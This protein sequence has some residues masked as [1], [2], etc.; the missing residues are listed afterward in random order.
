[1]KCP[2]FSLLCPQY[3]DRQEKRAVLETNIDDESHLDHATNM[4]EDTSNTFKGR[5][6]ASLDAFRLHQPSAHIVSSCSTSASASPSSVSGGSSFD[7]EFTN[8]PSASLSATKNRAPATGVPHGRRTSMLAHS[9]IQADE[10]QSDDE[11]H[12]DALMDSGR[13]ESPEKVQPPAH[14]RT[15]SSLLP[16]PAMLGTSKSTRRGLSPSPGSPK[17]SPGRIMQEMN[18][19]DKSFNPL[20]P[21]NSKPQ[22]GTVTQGIRL[23]TPPP[24]ASFT[25][26][27]FTS[28]PFGGSTARPTGLARSKTSPSMRRPRAS[29]PSASSGYSESR[30]PSRDRALTPEETQM[31]D[32]AVNQTA[33]DFQA[34]FDALGMSL[35]GDEDVLPSPISRGPVRRPVQR[36]GS[37]MVRTPSLSTRDSIQRLTGPLF[38]F[39]QPKSKQH[40][41]VAQQLEDEGNDNGVDEVLSEAALHRLNSSRPSMNV[42]SAF[43]STSKA[44]MAPVPSNFH[45]NPSSYPPQNS[46]AA[47]ANRFPESAAED[48]FGAAGSSP[49]SENDDIASVTQFEMEEDITGASMSEAESE[50]KK[51]KEAWFGFRERPAPNAGQQAVTGSASVSST[52]ASANNSGS[53]QNHGTTAVSRPGKRKMV[54]DE[55]FEPYNTNSFKRR[56]VSPSA[57]ISPSLASPTLSQGS[58]SFG[59]PFQASGPGGANTFSPRSYSR[60]GSPAPMNNPH[61]KEKLSS[62]G[63]GSALGFYLA[64]RLSGGGSSGKEEDDS[65]KEVDMEL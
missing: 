49:D 17:A 57:S 41:R 3:K 14:P 47:T 53:S 27:M 34:S 55:R 30:R 26:P 46:Q 16:P 9:R 37:L 4:N 40:L 18:L 28:S 25:T 65:G 58:G 38:D 15:H 45:A 60:G 11:D 63:D 20:N 8:H 23:P 22:H 21:S 24:E 48:D 36:R 50:S 12:E 64:Q 6:A 32:S 31:D 7:T 44:F 62:T 5:F 29:S 54:S 56:A 2:A 35:P 39:P 61:A 1:M 51:S 52:P 19:Q 42:P 33:E 43:P 13:S 10:L 59:P